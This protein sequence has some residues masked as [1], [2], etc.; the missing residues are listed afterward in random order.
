M[1]LLMHGMIK[2]RWFENMNLKQLRYFIEV[3][4]QRSF[5][6]AAHKLYICQSALSKMIKVLEEDL[7][8]KLIERQGKHFQ[9]TSEGE[10]LYENGKE[11]LTRTNDELNVLIDSVHEEKGKLSLGIPPVIGTAY[12]P[13][14]IYAFRKKYPNIELRIYEEGANTVKMKV[15]AGKLDIGIVI[16]PFASD[17]VDIVPI[18]NSKNVAVVHHTHPLAHRKEISFIE[19]KAEKFIILNGT[20]MLHDQILMKCKE[21]GFVPDIVIESSQWDFIAQMIQMNQGI[22]I[23]PKPIMKKFN[24]KDIRL[25]SLK[26]PEFP[27]DIAMIRMKNKYKSNPVQLFLK[28]MKTLDKI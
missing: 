22:T 18:F 16:M 13:E 20:Y 28:F 27:W 3:A 26:N 12:F 10:L 14:I 9:L 24:V 1:F 11:I 4:E 21:S 2:K 5:T 7:E 19:L 8:V 15:E 25:L 17:D 6:K 23:L